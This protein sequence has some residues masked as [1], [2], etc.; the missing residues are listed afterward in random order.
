MGKVAMNN[1]YSPEAHM[2][3]NGLGIANCIE[4]EPEVSMNYL[5]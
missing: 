2:R 1:L 4:L 3:P 5:F